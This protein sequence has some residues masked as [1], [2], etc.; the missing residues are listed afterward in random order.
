MARNNRCDRLIRIP[1]PVTSKAST[2]PDRVAQATDS[3]RRC[4]GATRQHAR[5]RPDRHG[6]ADATR[7]RPR[8]RERLGGGRERLPRYPAGQSASGQ[9][10]GGGVAVEFSTACIGEA[11]YRSAMSRLKSRKRARLPDR[12]FAYIDARGRRRLP[13]HD[14]AHVRNALA[15][16]IQVAFE[17][18]DAPERAHTHLLIPTHQT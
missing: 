17:R 5:R 18:Y 2:S 8:G 12:A 10:D 1:T 16:F 3:T 14:K 6:A 7:P 15:R 4:G 13:I 11:R 9:A